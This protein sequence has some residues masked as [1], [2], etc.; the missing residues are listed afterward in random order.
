MTF[1]IGRSG[2]GS[3]SISGSKSGSASTFALDFAMAGVEMGCRLGKRS[4]M[5]S[6]DWKFFWKFCTNAGTTLTMDC[7][8]A[9]S[10]SV[11]ISLVIG[12]LIGVSD[13]TMGCDVVRRRRKRRPEASSSSGTVMT[14]SGWGI[15]RTSAVARASG[16][17]I[18]A[19][20]AMSRVGVWSTPRRFC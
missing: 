1:R 18:R 13:S 6:G 7:F 15:A 9:D 16:D 3:G 11:V 12:S 2:K 14:G 19:G 4:F 10:F 8:S 5:R 20:I 17:S